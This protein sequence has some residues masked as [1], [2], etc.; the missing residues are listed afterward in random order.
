VP[1]EDELHCVKTGTVVESK[2]GTERIITSKD[3]L[4][5]HSI[6]HLIEK[7]RE[8]SWICK[9]DVCN[10]VFPGKLIRDIRALRWTL[11]GL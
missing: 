6:L 1:L 9:T 10:F 3:Q 8:V 5:S 7:S 2:D 4:N 11:A